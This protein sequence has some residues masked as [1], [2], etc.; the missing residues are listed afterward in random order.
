MTNKEYDDFNDPYEA[1]I[2]AIY[3][4]AVEDIVSESASATDRNSAIEFLKKSE[5][6]LKCLNI[7]EKEGKYNGK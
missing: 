5:L 3:H 2:T 4:Q 7:L 1:L 6:G